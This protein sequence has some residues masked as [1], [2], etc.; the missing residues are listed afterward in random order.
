MLSEFFTIFNCLVRT[1]GR[2][3][4]QGLT[5]KPAD[6]ADEATEVIG[7]LITTYPN[8][9]RVRLRSDGTTEEMKP[10]MISVASDPE[11]KQVDSET[12]DTSFTFAHGWRK[13]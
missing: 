4:K 9:D 11:T 7:A 10:V 1:G 6:A 13:Q 5:D 8:G 12:K 2:S 3:S